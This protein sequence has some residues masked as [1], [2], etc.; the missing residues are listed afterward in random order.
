MDNIIIEPPELQ[1][2]IIEYIMYNSIAKV[3]FS[4]L[5]YKIQKKLPVSS[6]IL[7]K[8]L[9]YLIEYGLLSYEG[10]TQKFVMTDEGFHLL[11]IINNDNINKKKNINEIIVTL[12][13]I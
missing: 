12:D 6:F 2:L 9:Y 1:T 11:F 7:K 13:D 4:D 10:K 5:L 8:C 3:S